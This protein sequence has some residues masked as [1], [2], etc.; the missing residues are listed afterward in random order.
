MP[1]HTY[2]KLACL[3]GQKELA[4]FEYKVLKINLYLR[5]EQ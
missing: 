1:F 2:I 5:E 4:V 3:Y